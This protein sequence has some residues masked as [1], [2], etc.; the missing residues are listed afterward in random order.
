MPPTTIQPESAPGAHEFYRVQLRRLLARSFSTEELKTLA[1]DLEVDFDELGSEAKTS[2]IRELVLH[3]ERQNKLDALITAA[4]RE[5]PNIH[6]PRYAEPDANCPYRGLRPFGE[7]NATLFFGREQFTQQLVATVHQRALVAVV[8]SSGSGKSSVV[9]AGLVPYLHRSGDWLIASLRPGTQPLHELAKA[10]IPLLEHDRSETEQLFAVHKLRE[11][12]ERGNVPLA[13]VLQRIL[14]KHAGKN[15][16]L[17][18]VDQF[19]ELYTNCSDTEMR[20]QFLD[21]MLTAL[22][23]TP[24]KRSAKPSFT[25]VLTLR[26]D[27]MGHALGYRPL[28]DSLQKSD[29]KLGPMTRDELEEAIIRP[30]QEANLVFDEGLVERILDDIVPGGTHQL[31]SGNLPLLQFALEQLWALRTV[32]GRMT[33][34][35]YEI[36]GEVGGAISRYADE[37]YEGLTPLEQANIR[38]ILVQMVHLGDVED[39]RRLVTRSEIGNTNWALVKQLAEERLV[40]TDHDGMGQ[41]IAEVIHEALIQKWSRMQQWI[42]EDRPFRTWQD[43]L[44]AGLARWQKSQTDDDL[45]QG[46]LLSTSQEWLQKRAESLNPQENAFLQRSIAAKR[47]VNFRFALLLVLAGGTGAAVGAACITALAGYIL[48]RPDDVRVA[49][50]S[51]VAFTFLTGLQGGLLGGFQGLMTMFGLVLANSLGWKLTRYSR[52]IC[53]FA[54]GGL[55]GG[56]LF[57]LLRA[58]ESF[59]SRL[60][61]GT[62]FIVGLVVFGLSSAAACAVVPETWSASDRLWRRIMLGALAAGIACFMALSGSYYLI[63]LTGATPFLP[64]VLGFTALECMFGAGLNFG[65]GITNRVRYI[66]QSAASDGHDV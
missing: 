57:I 6:W 40:I 64:T 25:F 41:E 56:V 49:H 24:T 44:R 47:G 30:A 61:A 33:H 17:L 45:L 55:A 14:A 13:D 9:F 37:L 8:G 46:T 43:H 63:D 27:F 15:Q 39:T 18:V 19:E 28:A 23:A 16:L 53:S 26:G 12:L 36:I 65:L 21:I 2:K 32:Q 11:M 54:L 31:D 51:R 42:Q 10:L 62:V 4:A 59:P 3:L 60:S 66:W 22:Q 35:A 5:R 58:A 29:V 1:F 7:Q 34:A 52:T 48:W 20:Q 38:G 50:I